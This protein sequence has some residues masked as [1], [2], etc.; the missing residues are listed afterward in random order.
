MIE[1]KDGAVYRDD[2]PIGTVDGDKLIVPEKLHHKVAEKIAK[3][4]G[5][6]IT[7]ATPDGN[8]QE[9]PAAPPKQPEPPAKVEE[10]EPPKDYRGDKTPAFVDW[11]FRNRPQEAANRYAN[12]KISR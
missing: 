3:E 4:T 10:P 5:L 8:P 1:I 6:T 12:R 11:M 2:E 7:V 9:P